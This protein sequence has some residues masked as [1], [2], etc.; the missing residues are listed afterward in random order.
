MQTGAREGFRVQIPTLAIPLGKVFKAE[1]EGYS[2]MKMEAT[3]PNRLERNTKTFR[4][5]VNYHDVVMLLS[6][7]KVTE[8]GTLSFKGSYK[9][10]KASILKRVESFISDIEVGKHVMDTGLMVDRP[11]EGLEAYSTA[12]GFLIH[13]RDMVKT[14]EELLGRMKEELDSFGKEDRIRGNDKGVLLQIYR[15]MY[16]DAY[17]KSSLRLEF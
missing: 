3:M 6:G 9:E 5:A 14:Y 10:I 15:E 16:R 7:S 1:K 8:A 17:N 12:L 13:H 2:G 4:E 11:F